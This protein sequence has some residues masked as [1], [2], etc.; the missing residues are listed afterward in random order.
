MVWDKNED[1]LK[2]IRNQ[3]LLDCRILLSSRPHSTLEIEKYFPTVVRVDGFTEK[4]AT[5]FVSNFFTDKSKIEQIMRFKPSDYREDFPVHKCP[6]LLS[7]LCFLW[8]KQGVDLSDE[9]ITVGDWYFKMVKCL[10]KKYTLRKGVAFQ[11]SEL[12]R[13]MKSVGQLALCTLLSNRP[14]LQR[15]EVLRIAG[16]F[17]LEYGFFTGHEDF[18]DPAADIDVTYAHRSIEECFWSF[19]FIQSLDDGKSVDDILGPDC[20]EPLFMVNPLVLKFC[21]WL[22]T[23]EYLKSSQVILDKLTFYLCERMNSHVLNFEQFVKR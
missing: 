11:V 18:T 8:S 19:G 21:L 2:I 7:I 4:E 10:Y 23:T 3:Q 5:K 12:I 1:V 9:N 20:E 17:A 13:V 22:L 15:S 16:D 14:L 6:I